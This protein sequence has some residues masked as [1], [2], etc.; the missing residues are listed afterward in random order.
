MK[1]A[2][3]QGIMERGLYYSLIRQIIALR[4]NKNMLVVLSDLLFPPLGASDGDSKSIKGFRR[5]FS[6][7]CVTFSC[8]LHCYHPLEMLFNNGIQCC[9]EMP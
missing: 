7:A 1:A 2:V 4:G 6:D 9:G 5:Y 8:W 3:W